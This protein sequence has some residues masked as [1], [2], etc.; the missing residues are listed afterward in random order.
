MSKRCD[1]CH[2]RTT[3]RLP[4]YQPLIGPR[5]GDKLTIPELWR[6]YPCPECVPAVA[7]ERIALVSHLTAF[8]SRMNNSD[9]IRLAQESAAHGLVAG[10]LKAGFIEFYFGQEDRAQ[11]TT[12][13]H[14]TL[15]VVSKRHVASLE[16]RITAR[17]T[18]IAKLA[19]E[20]AVR[21]IRIWGS[22]YSGDEGRIFKGQAI[23]TVNKA[24][25]TV[26]EQRATTKV[27]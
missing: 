27:A 20:E 8:D 11:L 5:H 21:Q 9:Y 4:I 26:L 2:G 15:G 7:E 24:L 13:L 6:E 12:P 3:I 10:L 1:V 19:V 16:E 17:Q 18:E 25:T 14:A 22:A 23:D